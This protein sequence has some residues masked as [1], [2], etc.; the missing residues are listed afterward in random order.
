M[1]PTQPPLHLLCL[2]LLLLYHDVQQCHCAVV[3][4]FLVVPGHLVFNIAI[5]ISQGFGVITAFFS[6]L[7]LL[8]AVFQVGSLLHIA[9]IMVHSMWS[10]GVNPDNS[11][12]PY[13]TAMGD[14]LGGAFLA[15]VF[16][17]IDWT[18]S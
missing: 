14:L 17:I 6:F 2:L 5:G 15:A 16:Q 9:N 3:L 18:D 8:A 7:Y 4:L 12:I 1:Q 10:R 13:L 11:A